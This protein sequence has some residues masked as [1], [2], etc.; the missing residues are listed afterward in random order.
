MVGGAG[1]KDAATLWGKAME[2]DWMTRYEVKEAI[3]PAY[4][5]F[6]GAQTMAWLLNKA[7]YVQQSEA[8]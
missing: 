8:I 7:N 1:G 6:L 5:K 2:I 4:T 3:P